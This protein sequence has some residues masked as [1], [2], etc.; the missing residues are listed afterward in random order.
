M[1]TTMP[2]FSMIFASCAG[3][4][5]SLAK[6]MFGHRIRFAVS[7]SPR[8]ATLGQEKR[9][10][11]TSR[12]CSVVFAPQIHYHP[13][14]AGLSVV[15]LQGSAWYPKLMRHSRYGGE[16][17]WRNEESRHN[18][19]RAIRPRPTAIRVEMRGHILWAF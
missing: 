15:K 11:P 16:Q 8:H 5:L 4:G 6:K 18:E 17:G 9:T 13:P 14:G 7:G 12:K 1:A 19:A 2:S 3:V 10:C